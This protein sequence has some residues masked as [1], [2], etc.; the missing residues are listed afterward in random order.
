MKTISLAL[1]RG[2]RRAQRIRRTLSGR[3]ALVAILAGPFHAGA[4]AVDR[5]Y[6]DP[7]P[8][9]EGGITGRLVAPANPAEQILAIPYDRP[10]HVYAGTFL[11]TER[12]TF[13]FE[14]L[15]MNRYDL[16]VIYPDKFFEGLTLT[17]GENTLTREDE[18]QIRETIER[19]EKFFT[20]K[21]PHRIAGTTGRGNEARAICT[22]LR[23]RFSI[24]GSG[25]DERR[26]EY[27]RTFKLV[28]LRD[29]G[30]GWQIVRTRD[31]YPVYVDPDRG[32][33]GH[34]FSRAVHG[35][36]VTSYIK[37]LGDISLTR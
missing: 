16:V 14:G 22:F 13:M 9:A 6:T 26:D 36:R 32:R 4:A 7:D 33:P 30:P 8:A 2:P 5:I 25:M 12:R 17:R 10:E 20:V 35:I 11:D 34:H 15:P 24:A 37:E 29:V 18:K 27:R 31:L 28:I 3:I 1:P 21:I 19:S 23:D